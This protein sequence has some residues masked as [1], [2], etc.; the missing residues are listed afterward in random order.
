MPK[1]TTIYTVRVVYKSGYTHDFDVLTFSIDRGVYKWDPVDD[2]NKPL[3]L[4][5]DDIAAFWQVGM[6]K[7]L[8]WK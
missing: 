3:L 6:R 4:G 2:N 1:F 7:R 5:V 8:T